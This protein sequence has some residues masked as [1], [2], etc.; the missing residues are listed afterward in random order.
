MSTADSVSA[1]AT[2]PLWG[3]LRYG[4][5]LA[6]LIAVQALRRPARRAERQPVLLIPGFMAGD[7]SL[8]VLRGWLARRG[9]AVAMS[10]IRWNVGCAERIVSRLQ[11]EV[12]ALASEH[13]GSIAVIGQS[14]GGALA[15]ALAVR[16]G[17]HVSRLAMLGSPVCDSLAVAPRVLQTVR[18]MARL[19]DLG[20]PGLFSSSCADGECCVGFWEDLAAP[21]DPRTESLA[22][23]SKSDA[24]V[25]WSACID[26]HSRAV[27]VRSSHCGMSVHPAVYRELE[28][29]FE[30]EREGVAW[31]G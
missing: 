18:W 1:P 21:L 11:S 17:E 24:I 14:R 19:G 13:G 4:G 10:G 23:Y 7:G 16:E 6:R 12:R 30:D 26:P 25:D 2:A 3:E 27:E 22:V 8:A 9:H 29:M 28:L 5:E 20:I 31:N 15:R